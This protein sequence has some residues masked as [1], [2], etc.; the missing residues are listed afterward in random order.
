[1]FLGLLAL[2]VTAT[3]YYV[4][5]NSTNPTPPYTNWATASTDIQSAI[6]VSTTGDLVLVNDGIYQTG[7]RT[8]NGYGLTNRV[9]IDQAIAVESIDGPAETVIEGYQMP[10]TTNGNSA[11]RCVYMTNNAVLIGFTLT[12]GATR[13]YQNYANEDYEASGGGVWCEDNS[14]IVSNCVLTAN[15]AD[16]TFGVGG[17]AVEG[18]LNNCILIGNL[19]E[20]GGGAYA[21]VMNNCTLTEN[22]AIVIHATYAPTGGGAYACT[23]NQCIL[24][25]NLAGSGGG[26]E[27]SVLNGCTITNNAVNGDG[28][29]VGRSVLNNCIISDNSAGSGGGTYGSILTNCTLTG[30]SAYAGGA[31]YSDILNGCILSSNSASNAGGAMDAS[32]LTNC[33]VMNNSAGSAGGGANGGTLYNCVLSGNVTFNAGGGVNSATVYN[34]ALFGNSAVENG[35]GA[36]GSTLISCTL[37][38]NSALS[39]GGTYSCSLTN[40]IVYYNDAQIGTNYDAASSLAYSCTTPLPTNGPGNI[41]DAPDL[42][43]NFHLGTDSPCIGAGNPVYVTGVDIDGNSWMNPPS[44]G[45]SEFYPN[46]ATGQL[47]VAIDATFTNLA[48]GFTGSFAA[49]INGHASLSIWNFGDGAEIVNQPDVSHMWTTPGVYQVSLWTYND[50]NPSGVSATITVQVANNPVQYV[51]QGN[52]TSAAPYLSWATAATNIQDAV[53]DAFGGGTILVSNGVY[54]SSGYTSPAGTRCVTVTRPILL[55][56]LNG[57]ATTLICGSNSVSCVYLANGAL[58]SGFTLTN[59][60]VSGLPTDGGGVFCASTT[61]IITN[62]TLINNLGDRGGGAFSGTLINCILLGNT[63]E[64]GGGAAFSTLLGCSIMG[65]QTV[66]SGNYGGAVYC[67]LSNCVVNGNLRGG[68]GYCTLVDCTIESNT[69]PENGDNGGGAAQSTLNNCL[70]CGNQSQYGG[71]AYDC[72]LNFCVISNNAADNDGGGVYD[73]SSVTNPGQS[74]VIVGNLVNNGY[75]GGMY[76]AESYGQNLTLSSWTFI[77]N[78]ATGNG[79]NGGGIYAEGSVSNCTFVGN[80]AGGNGGGCYAQSSLVSDCTFE[81]N[82]TPGMGGG[83][84][85]ILTN[86][87]LIGNKADYGGGAYGLAYNCNFNSNLATNNGGGLYAYYYQGSTLSGVLANC[88]FTN[89]SALNG[90][91]VYES[92]N[93]YLAFSNCLFLANTATNDGGGI[94]GADYAELAYCVLRNNSA[95]LDGGGVYEPDYI[96][97]CQLNGNSAA[98]G[99]G[100]FDSTTTIPS[101]TILD[102]TIAGNRATENGGGIYWPQIPDSE[103]IN[104]IIYNNS[105]PTNMNYAPTNALNTGFGGYQP[106]ASYC[107]TIPLPLAAPGQNNSNFTNDPAFVNPAAG[108]FHLQSYSPCINSGTNAS[109]VGS[110]DLDGNPRIVGGTVDMGAYEDQTPASMV[111]Y[112]WLQQYGLP[113]TTNTDAS[114]PNGTSF[115]VYQDWIAG[116][117]PTNPASVLVMLSPQ[118]TNNVSGIMV[119]WESVT[120]IPYNLQRTTNVTS[121]FT[122]IQANINGHAGTTSYTDT[123]ATG[124]GP[125]FYRV[126]VP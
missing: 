32:T 126:V 97:N 94:A 70:I 45:C 101:A 107:C 123:T 69:P 89:N 18:T 68:V 48:T 39:G 75:G 88:T 102:S 14:A 104:C 109:V 92:P 64:F 22:S 12:N 5:I 41:A 62:C 99:G 65:N 76:F 19:A 111:S 82:T 37:T 91:G 80:F 87:Y 66:G 16:F 17:G 73:D 6:D 31:S 20:A 10:G 118:P 36:A 50:S 61:T 47:A 23:L 106:G 67:T 71:G 40:C 53:N 85:S 56:S 52:T 42:A 2:K 13:L 49:Q 121:A 58:L 122:T 46:T 27:V 30:N 74:N 116:L 103:V 21:S 59:G 38:G 72:T 78:S 44:M 86:C 43:D 120:N 110:T 114:S 29:G 108:D 9:V 83:A 105:A 98:Y 112:H 84:Y 25:G 90:G 15:A 115:D 55:Q 79:G 28:G 24:A 34:S 35:G 77:S 125:Y 100:V 26:A 51:A 95:G 124:N 93:S 63:G 1:M 81:G 57:P 117:N 33:I 60:F 8:V 11:V 113:I 3:T 119:T 7:G 4:D 54:Q 96:L